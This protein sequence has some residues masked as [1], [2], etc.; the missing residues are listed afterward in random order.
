MDL[1]KIGK[2][3]LMGQLAVLWGVALCFIA[4]EITAIA[5][6]NGYLTTTSEMTS[7]LV[8]RQSNTGQTFTVGTRDKIEVLLDENPSTGYSWEF[9]EQDRDILV[10]SDSS[11]YSGGAIPGKSG[12]RK[13]QFEVKAPGKNTILF[14]LSQPWD[15]ANVIEQFQVTIHVVED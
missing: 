13:F 2:G 15:R 9:T 5:C 7:M 12:T 8:I 6:T 10:F 1:T 3:K 4:V 11:F 14:R